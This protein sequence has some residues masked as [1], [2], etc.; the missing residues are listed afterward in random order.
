MNKHEVGFVSDVSYKNGKTYM[1]LEIPK[2]I[3]SDTI[4]RLK[5]E[6]GLVVGVSII[7]PRM[8]SPAQ[9]KKANILLSE[10]GE[11][12]GMSKEESRETI[13]LEYCDKKGIEPFSITD[14]TL[15]EARE[16]INFLV[17]FIL[18]NKIPLKSNIRTL[19]DDMNR[20]LFLC[21]KYRTCVCC[22]KR[23]E[24][25]HIDTIG[26]GGDRRKVDHTKKDMVALCTV[27]HREAHNIGWQSFAALHHVCGIRI[28]S[29]TVKFLNL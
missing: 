16:F 21:V 11:W 15:Q 3:D 28:N 14:M 1:L 10:I 2:I 17:E 24:I 25:H 6:R 29:D 13:K 19:S 18:Y 9:N 7:D 4:T 20:T 22:G 23:A 8:I 12:S 5:T 27:H 26:M